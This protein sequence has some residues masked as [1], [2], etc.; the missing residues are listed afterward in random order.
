LRL[1]THDNKNAVYMAITI[2]HDFQKNDSAGIKREMTIRP[3]AYTSILKR[4]WFSSPMAKW[5]EM[6][7]WL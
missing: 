7:V 1:N 2:E 6:D 3:N 4:I 5:G